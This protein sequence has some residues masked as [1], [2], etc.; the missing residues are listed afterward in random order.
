MENEDQ[1]SICNSNDEVRID[2]DAD[3]LDPAAV[4][5]RQVDHR[6][7][8]NRE[9]YHKH[10]TRSTC[11]HCGNEYM[12]VSSLRKHERRSTKC[13]VGVMKKVFAEIIPHLEDKTELMAK[14]TNVP[15]ITQDKSDLTTR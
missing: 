11:E 12:S 7:T 10:K 13:Q 8:Y 14:L 4:R 15:R 1:K 5:A 3:V 6:R 2:S 9:Y